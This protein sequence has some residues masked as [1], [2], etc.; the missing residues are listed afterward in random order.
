[1]NARDIAR[2]AFDLTRAIDW[3]RMASRWSNAWSLVDTARERVNDAAIDLADLEKFDSS[4]WEQVEFSDV[5]ADIA[6]L[7]EQNHTINVCAIVE[8][9]RK[10]ARHN[11][12]PTT[13]PSGCIIIT[14]GGV[15]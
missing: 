10:A 12:V 13:L 11:R 8:R 5:C 6:E 1:M 4:V 15:R 2:N 7:I 3:A 9:R 14:K